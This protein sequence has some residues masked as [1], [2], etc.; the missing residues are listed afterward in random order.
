MKVK[1]GLTAAV[2][3]AAASAS[4]VLAQA[5]SEAKPMKAK[6]MSKGSA[7]RLVTMPASDMKWMDLDPKGAPG[8]KVADVWGDHTKGAYGAFIKFPAGW[9]APLHTHTNDLKIVVVSGTSC[10][11]AGTT[12]TRPGVTRPPSA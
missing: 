6:P 9:A 4:M 7:S 11:P 8:V 10:S 12:R 1:F 5:A 3:F 2:V